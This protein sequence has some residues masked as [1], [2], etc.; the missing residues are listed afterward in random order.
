MREKS[1]AGLA[2]VQLGYVHQRASLWIAGS[3]GV[4]ARPDR[5]LPQ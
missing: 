1:L 2:G 3:N 5:A 4:P